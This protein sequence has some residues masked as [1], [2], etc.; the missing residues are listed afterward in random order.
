MSLRVSRGLRSVD[1]GD[2]D[3]YDPQTCG[4]G[5]PEFSVRLD[6]GRKSEMLESSGGGGQRDN[7]FP[8]ATEAFSVD[9][10]AGTNWRI[11]M[12]IPVDDCVEHML[13]GDIC[14]RTI[15]VCLNKIG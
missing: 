1:G 7:L 13:S 8:G 11:Q 2:L 9:L 14:K 4:G 15:M 12:V 3:V 10:L 5:D 6:R